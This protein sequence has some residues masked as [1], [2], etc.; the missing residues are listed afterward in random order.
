MDG[1]QSGL[2]RV[3]VFG[4]GFSGFSSGEGDAEGGEGLSCSLVVLWWHK[5]GIG[6][7]I[8]TA[9]AKPLLFHLLDAIF[10]CFS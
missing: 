2:N 9:S 6:S 7:G 1:C 5:S 10:D 4:F 3:P 8:A